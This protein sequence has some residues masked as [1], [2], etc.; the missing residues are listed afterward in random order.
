MKAARGFVSSPAA[1]HEARRFVRECLDRWGLRNDDIRPVE[2]AASELVSNAVRHGGPRF[3][4][5]VGVVAGRVRVE[6][7]DDGGGSPT[8]RSPDPEHGGWGLRLVARLADVWANDSS[9][10]ETVVWFER[11]VTVRGA[12]AGQANGAGGDRSF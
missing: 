10:G 3:V 5:R 11:T 8:L 1:A 9:D 4:V 6:V 12:V 7:C 2:L